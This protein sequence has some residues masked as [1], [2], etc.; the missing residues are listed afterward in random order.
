MAPNNKTKR[1]T[2]GERPGRGVPEVFKEIS[3]RNV[4]GLGWRADD[5]GITRYEEN[6]KGAAP[7]GGRTMAF[8]PSA[9]SQGQN[10][11]SVLGGTP[12]TPAW[13]T[14][15][16]AGVIPL[17]TPASKVLTPAQQA[18]VRQVMEDPQQAAMASGPIEGAK[19]FLSNLFNYEDSY[20]A[21]YKPGAAEG[22]DNP[23][24][25]VWDGMLKGLSWGYDTLNHLTTAALS[26]MPGG[27][28]TLTWEESQ[29]VSVGQQL[30]A[31]AGV[32]AGRIRRGEGSV[33]DVVGN[34]GIPLLGGLIAGAVDP[35]TEIQREGWDITKEQD[36]KAF[37]SGWEKAF[38][39]TTDLA[40][41]LFADPLIIGGK[42]AKAA[43]IKWVDRVVDTE[44]ARIVLRQE[45]A[46]GAPGMRETATSVMSPRAMF[47]DWATKTDDLGNKAVTREEIFYHPVIARAAKRDQ[48]AAALYNAQDYETGALLLRYAYGDVTAR[49]ELFA[50]RADI[51]DAMGRS[52]WERLNMIYQLNPD[53]KARVESIA[54]KAANKANDRVFA[55]EQAGL[56]GSEE[57]QLAVRMRTNANDMMV[58]INKGKFDPIAESTPESIALAKQVYRARVHNDQVLAK[59]IGDEYQRVGGVYGALG[60]STKGFAVDNRFGRR[61]EARRQAK[62][63]AKYETQAARGRQYETDKVIV[64]KDESG[65]VISTAKEMRTARPWKKSYWEVDEFNNNGFRRTV[66]LWRWMA[67][68]NPSGFIITKGLGAQESTREVIAV[69][70]DVNI[71][72]GAARKI[73]VPKQIKDKATGKIKETMVEV[74]VGGVKRK[75]EL[76]G[77][78]MDALNDTVAGADNAQIALERVEN[79]IFNDI[80]SW[81]GIS[82]QT[83]EQIKTKADDVRRGHMESLRDPER[84]FWIDDDGSINKA[85]WLESQI[86]NGTY[87]LN[88]RA[89]EKAA[90]L[91]D[92][93]GAAKFADE[94]GTFVGKNFMTVYDVFNDFWRPA[95]LMR[96]GYTQ[97]NVM[98]GWFRAAAMQSSL[99]P[100]MYG[101]ANGAYSAKN[102]MVNFRGQKIAQQAA[103]AA[104]LRAAGNTT[105]K[106]PKK[107]QKWLE[108][109][110][111]AREENIADTLAYMDDTSVRLSVL[112][113]EY[114][115]FAVGYLRKQQNYALDRK[116]AAQQAG[117]SQD[118]LASWQAMIDDAAKKQREILK[119]KTFNGKN[120]DSEIAF[121][122]LRYNDQLLDDSM[123]RRLMLD[124]DEQSVALYQ[125]QGRARQR[126]FSGSNTGPEGLVTREAFD[127]ESNFTP[128]ALS[129]LSS[130][131][132][133]KSMLELRMEGSIR[134]FRATRKSTFQTVNPGDKNY[135]DGLASMLAQVDNSALG[136]RIIKGEAD[137]EI[138]DFL[139]KTREGREIMDFIMGGK[140]FGVDDAV[141]AVQTARTRY[142]QLLPTPEA[143]EFMRGAVIDENW[144]GRALESLLGATDANGAFIHKLNPVVG[145]VEEVFGFKTAMDWWR[146]FTS[147]GMKYLGTLPEDALVRQ[148]FY[149]TRHA[150]VLSEL[151][152]E[153]ESQVGTI[154]QRELDA[155]QRVAHARALKDTKDWLYTIERRTNLGT[156]GEMVLPFVSAAQNSITTVGRIAWNDP[157]VPALM[158]RLWNAP[159]Q[160]G[161]EDEDG[162][163]IIP[164]PHDM[165]PDG[166]EEA[167][168]LDTMMNWTFKKSQL[169][170]IV[171]ETGFG[172]APRPGPLVGVPVNE[173]MKRGWLGMS[174][175]SP[176]FLR[177]IL[178]GKEQADQVWNV[179][180]AY[181]FG[182][183]QG[184][185]PNSLSLLAPPVAQKVIQM[186]EGEG[187]AQF[188]YW[189]NLQYRSEWANW[190]AGYRDNMP[191]KDEIMAK[192]RGFYMVRM[193]A[194]LTAI[195][196]PQYESIIDP[197]V[198]ISRKYD[199]MYPG[200][201]ARL[202]NQQ[203]GP[204]LQM[205]GDYSNSKNV[206]GMPPTADAVEAARKYSDLIAEVSPG[207]ERMGDLSAL[208]MLT[209]GK[210]ASGLYD[211]SAYGWQ[212]ANDIPGINETFRKYQTP[213][214]AWT[215]SKINAGWTTY[216]TAMDQFDARLESLGFTSYRQAPELQAEKN[217]FL[218]QMADNPMFQEWWQDYKEFG[219]SRTLS[220]VTT[221]TAALSNPKFSEDMRDSPIWQNASQ[222][223]YHRQAV[224]DELKNR[225]GSIDAADNEDI[226]QYWDDVRS[227]LSQNKEWAAF[228]NRFLNGDDNPQEPG[229]Q[230]LDYVVTPEGEAA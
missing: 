132:T 155:L 40:F 3:A 188:A 114:R 57:W 63:K 219:S 86:Q 122:I 189:Y 101:I 226:R 198:D 146:S 33:W 228:Q 136:K 140:S 191:S 62:A 37:E 98:E 208:T 56:R 213:E 181:A 180:K 68:E 222:Y 99:K 193:A 103:N 153:L 34:G 11:T 117:A 163:I 32:S 110:I 78:Y 215:Q 23:V 210:T 75:Q 21:N 46:A 19:T 127:A 206:A 200:E 2:G 25:A 217:E 58:K 144:N 186:I 95:V 126:I 148:P 55:L 14:L 120:D 61:I 137:E 177:N 54:E 212:F 115:D 169:N 36:R 28:R 214:Q 229:V 225:E 143:Q 149:G 166:I 204:F 8:Q 72:S 207:L 183:G 227:F 92:E 47:V 196:P 45:L 128:V 112:D 102:A 4:S 94:A 10:A 5:F 216:M 171:P 145:N 12:Q 17:N 187:N 123:A 130:D 195:T 138:V 178:G 80:A 66:R 108:A 81:H 87:M 223:L 84:R 141:E 59:A 49:A 52:E 221:M 175:E 147:T 7:A 93:T 162:N 42:F 100:V 35:D 156:Y 159:N 139:Y 173:I 220:A 43:R 179:W 119:I 172:F 83:A 168:G 182:E 125:Q 64:R 167:L 224:L 60:D 124:S 91:Y 65:N 121:S 76:I 106:M 116:F 67:E 105:V 133:T 161:L 218:S 73:M 160:A 79:A 74:E 185:N 88:Y 209:M 170:F 13:G 89:L 107:Y 118:E 29:D 184:I 22:P 20:G 164:M 134:T 27:T 53:R 104:R 192:T 199:Q 176:D 90:R 152:R 131:S 26:A 211:D 129:M 44:E 71:Y 190:M 194:N 142:N 85:P 135:W 24:E 109:Q 157:S 51:V 197:L 154:T 41:T 77:M 70:D 203:F 158:A 230:L 6:V 9:A 31:N 150:K 96:L 174:V 69:L 111:I 205:I 50:R 15:P 113:P 97:R 165:I 201:S 82:K 151:R 39:G 18:Q 30:V 48:L 16:K 202:F 38:S 1:P